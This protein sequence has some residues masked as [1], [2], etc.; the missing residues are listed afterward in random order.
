CKSDISTTFSYPITGSDNYSLPGPITLTCNAT[1]D[2]QYIQWERLDADGD[3]LILNST[4]T[5]N[6]SSNW[7]ATIDNWL[8]KDKF[9]FTYRCIAVDSCCRKNVSEPKTLNIRP[10]S[11][12]S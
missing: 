8:L 1:G 5:R 4:T 2:L 7:I 11:F 9:P 3:T 10:N 12:F 6:V